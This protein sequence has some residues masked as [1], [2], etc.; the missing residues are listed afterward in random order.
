M[1]STELK[2]VLDEVVGLR[3]DYA[4]RMTALES[5]VDQFFDQ[6]EELLGSPARSTTKLGNFS[7]RLSRGEVNAATTDKSF[8]LK[9]G[10][11]A[12][13][14]IRSPRPSRTLGSCS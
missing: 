8:S 6:Q 2:T 12:E 5:R 13:E 3:T 10:A 7:A 4:K 1:A 14:S 9:I 11:G